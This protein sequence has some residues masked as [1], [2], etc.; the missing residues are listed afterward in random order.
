MHQRTVLDNGLRVLTT[1][2]P[3]TYSVSVAIFVGAGSRY[4]A[5]EVA[6]STHFLEHLLF[7]GTKSWPKAQDI[8]EA[9]E[10]VGGVMNASTDRE[11]TIYWCKVA[12]PHFNR[13]LS[14]LA[15]MVIN[16][17]LDPEE[18]EKERQVIQE[19][20][21]MSNDYPSHRVDLL[22]DEMLWPNQPMGRDVGGTKESVSAISRDDLVD[23]MHHQYAPAN[24]VVSVAGSVSHDEVVEALKHPVESWKPH[25]S[26]PWTP[27]Q[28][29]QDKAAIR[30]EYRK[31]EQAHLCVSL[32][33]LPL[34]H[35]DRYA[36]SLMNIM[37]GEG[38]SS[39]LFLEVREKQGLAY[40][41]HSSLSQ[42]HDCGSLIIYCGSEPSRSP[43]ALDAIMGQLSALRDGFPE[44]EVEKAREYSKGRMML[45]M[46]DS[47]SVVMWQGGQEMLLDKVLTVDEV[48]DAIDA[49]T[50]DD[51]N[52]I[53]RDMVK[54]DQL[55]LAIVGPFRSDRRFR[56]AF[57]L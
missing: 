39:R 17:L 35:P 3:E 57:K 13:A 37:L 45:R 8:S 9:I 47:R 56:S 24:V 52:R 31:S 26:R 38:M 12:K 10:G 51:V 20:L 53:A 2:M 32:P 46:E 41:V 23:L 22:I 54:E 29:G 34:D 5:D 55:N 44:K 6:G 28:L 33:G 48:V 7:K 27:A 11:I 49:V 4:E 19:E 16:P 18:M 21:R 25:D 14:V 40:D 1:T 30:V 43:R 36:M 42:F 15:D 50:V